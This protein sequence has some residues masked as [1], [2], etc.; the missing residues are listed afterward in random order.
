MGVQL[1]QSNK[2]G[3]PMKSITHV[4]SSLH[5]I[6]P[7]ICDVIDKCLVREYPYL[8]H[9][10]LVGMRAREVSKIA[11]ALILF[12]IIDFRDEWT[13]YNMQYAQCFAENLMIFNTVMNETPANEVCPFVIM[14]IS[15]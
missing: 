13:K 10:Y 5:E 9:N 4:Y 1:I 3:A 7:D 2:Q 6:F 14:N 8:K 11:Y 15:S 12:G